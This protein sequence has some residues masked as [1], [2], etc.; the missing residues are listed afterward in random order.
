MSAEHPKGPSAEQSGDVNGARAPEPQPRA[1]DPGARASF[2]DTL[3]IELRLAPSPN[4]AFAKSNPTIYYR[5][6]S[7]GL[8]FLLLRDARISLVVE[9]DWRV[10][11]VDDANF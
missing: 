6:P 8:K 10:R 2:H 11:E 1:V 3:A 4:S 9:R 5:D 7:G